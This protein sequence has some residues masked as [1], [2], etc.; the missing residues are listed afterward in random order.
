MYRLKQIIENAGENRTVGD[1]EVLNGVVFVDLN[2]IKFRHENHNWY[3]Q[4][5]EIW[6]NL[7]G[8]VPSYETEIEDN[9]LFDKV[10]DLENNLH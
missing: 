7:Q 2:G 5:G 10:E 4:C 1:V 9:L 8:G 6:V 3:Q